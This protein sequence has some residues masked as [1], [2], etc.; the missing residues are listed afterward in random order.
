M[1]T[2]LYVGNLAYEVTDDELRELFS[3]V[4][5]VKSAKV[6]QDRFSGRSKGFG[7]VE[8]ANEEDVERAIEEL[9]QREF[10]DR[11]LKVD[12]AR[13]GRGEGGGRRDRGGGRGGRGRR[14]GGFRQRREG[15][16]GGGYR[17]DYS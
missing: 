12:R 15:G 9:N 4:G 16:Y 1:S 3:E 11:S 7:F 13:G 2:E 5:E 17:D 14:E 10:H 6:I 8:M